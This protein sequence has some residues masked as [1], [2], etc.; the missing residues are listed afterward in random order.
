MKHEGISIRGHLY[1]TLETV[2]ACYRVEV[3]WLHE[4]YETGLLGSG[5]RVGDSTAIAAAQLDR[6]GEILRLSRQQGINL[7]G[8]LRLLDETTL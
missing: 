8:I 7:A 6:L 5:E 2:A 3:D 4:V 1:L